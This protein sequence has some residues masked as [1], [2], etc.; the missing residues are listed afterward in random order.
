MM[1]M[2]LSIMFKERSDF[3]GE[4]FYVRENGAYAISSNS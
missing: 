4:K 3:Y 2:C 1:E